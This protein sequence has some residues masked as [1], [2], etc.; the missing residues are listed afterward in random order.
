VDRY[1]TFPF[2]IQNLR[3]ALD[4]AYAVVVAELLAI[5]FIR[6]R[7]MRTGL[8]RTIVQVIIGGGIVFGVGVWLGQVGAAG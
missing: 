2:L 4:I 5:A 1:N 7:F 3:L 6:F 8:G